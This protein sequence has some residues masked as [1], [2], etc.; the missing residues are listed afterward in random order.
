MT[1][2]P[3]DDS[4]S[5]RL[6]EIGV[7]ISVLGVAPKSIVQACAK[8]Q[9]PSGGVGGGSVSSSLSTVQCRPAEQF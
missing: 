3:S 6:I 1:S 7:N 5:P 9:N 2:F 8:A 4:L